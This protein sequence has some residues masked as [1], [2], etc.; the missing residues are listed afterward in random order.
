MSSNE[1]EEKAPVVQEPTGEGASVEAAQAED[2]RK[3]GVSDE[4]VVKFDHV[5]K[6]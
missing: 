6:T 1:A 2:H 5:T 3:T 4:V